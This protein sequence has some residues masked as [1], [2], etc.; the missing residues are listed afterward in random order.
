L[1]LAGSFGATLRMLRIASG[2][3]E[4][5]CARHLDITAEELAD[6]ESGRLEPSAEFVELVARYFGGTVE[7]LGLV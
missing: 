6:I 2:V 1:A 4:A 3:S 5:S 7:G